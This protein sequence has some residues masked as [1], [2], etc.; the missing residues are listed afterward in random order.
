MINISEDKQI[1]LTQLVGSNKVV[2]PQFYYKI[3]EACT[4]MIA[5][6]EQ[7]YEKHKFWYNIGI[8]ILSATQFGRKIIGFL[9]ILILILNSKENAPE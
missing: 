9:N 2:L 7:H 3:V 4:S 8:K 6:I 5:W 1:D